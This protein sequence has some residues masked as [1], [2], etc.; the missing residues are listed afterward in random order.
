MTEG[1]ELHLEPGAGEPVVEGQRRI[2]IRGAEGAVEKRLPGRGQEVAAMEDGENLREARGREVGDR[3]TGTIR[4]SGGERSDTLTGATEGA[5]ER[6]D[7]LRKNFMSGIRHE[8]EIVA[9]RSMMAP[10][11]DHEALKRTGFDAR[12]HSSDARADGRPGGHA[13]GEMYGIRIEPE[14][15]G[16]GAAA[17]ENAERTRGRVAVNEAV[18]EKGNVGNGER[19]EGTVRGRIRGEHQGK[20]NVRRPHGEVDA[21]RR[22]SEGVGARRNLDS[23]LARKVELAVAAEAER[24]VAT[25]VRAGPVGKGARAAMAAGET[26][27]QMRAAPQPQHVEAGIVNEVV[28]VAIVEKRGRRK[29]GRERRRS[30]RRDRA[31]NDDG[32]RG[33]NGRRRKRGDSRKRRWRGG[34]SAVPTDTTGMDDAVLTLKRRRGGKNRRKEARTGE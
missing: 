30:R 23:D 34:G 3:R 2:R 6:N 15:G 29:K 26:L 27:R 18:A 21:A 22:R 19:E 31:R 32:R 5:N 16:E 25:V 8:A 33:A 14:T 20:R 24:Q 1:N 4:S 12:D 9:E 11:V 7:E 10:E 13:A 17:T 28:Q